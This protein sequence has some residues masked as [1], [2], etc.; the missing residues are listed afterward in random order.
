MTD[1]DTAT[2]LKVCR[3][4]GISTLVMLRPD[5][6]GDDISVLNRRKVFNILRDEHGW[7]APMLALICPLSV[8]TIQISLKRQ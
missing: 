3:D 5:K 6:Y 4:E 7:T 2:F 1:T 8:R